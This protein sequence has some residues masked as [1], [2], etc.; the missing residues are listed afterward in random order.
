MY[1][2]DISDM[3]KA[4][5]H[6]HIPPYTHH[7]VTVH[8]NLPLKVINKTVHCQYYAL[9]ILLTHLHG[10]KAIYDAFAR[11]KQNNMYFSDKFVHF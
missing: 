11:T 5:T 2:F 7:S 3:F 4:L 1:Q 8:H 6:T 10:V 9:K